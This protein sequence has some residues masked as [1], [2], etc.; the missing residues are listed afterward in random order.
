M[1]PLLAE[2]STFKL[3]LLSGYFGSNGSTGATVSDSNIGLTEDVVAG[4]FAAT[5]IMN[6]TGKTDFTAWCL[7]IVTYMKTS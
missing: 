4:G 6:G 7:D 2:A 1:T 5:G 3:D